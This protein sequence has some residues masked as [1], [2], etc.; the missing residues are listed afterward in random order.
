MKKL[1]STKYSAGA[2]NFAMLVLR[3]VF[4]ILIM[5]HGYDKLIHFGDRHASFMN[6][7]G[8][9]SSLSL[10]LVIFAEFFCGLFVILGLFTRLSVIPLIIVMAIAVVKAHH[11]AVFGDG[12]PATLYLTAFIV[13]LFVGPGRVSVDS[14]IGG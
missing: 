7:M 3:L 14:M 13:L 6:F 10:A 5:S 2:F 11:G 4:G 12:Q 9:G 1:L 8:I